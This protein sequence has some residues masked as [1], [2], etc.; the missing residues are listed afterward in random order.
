LGAVGCGSGQVRPN[1]PAVV[2]QW[3][4]A[5]AAVPSV[6]SRTAGSSDVTVAVIDG[7][8]DAIADLQANLAPAVRCRPECVPE[9]TPDPDGHGTSVA[10]VLGSVGDNRIGLAGVAWTVRI[11]PIAATD[12]RGELSPIAVAN[13][14]RWAAQ[15]GIRIAALP[16]TLGGDQPE[17]ERAIVES[18]DLLVVVPA[19][20]DGLDLDASGTSVQPCVQPA[21][22]VVCVT[23]LRPDGTIDE[24]SNRGGVSVDLA[25]PGIDVP[26]ADRRG[27]IIRVS[28]TSFAVP[29]VA[30]AA[31][32][33]LSAHPDA[34][35]QDL[36]DALRCGARPL[37]TTG[38]DIST[39]A[40]DVD[41]SLRVL[42][43]GSA[44][45]GRC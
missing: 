6:W 40:L 43:D 5:S 13:S 19:G 27:R 33:L 22:N 39:G 12:D 20:N 24:R 17:V 37:P 36:Q 34:T 4:L 41:V 1:D 16:L 32:L 23:A 10:S 35:T 3:G 15:H 14:V 30:G 21:P 18:P 7:G 2:D 26:A 25:A 8:V 44:T 29:M 42:D 31:A 45:I 9:A 38:A 11:V 28:G